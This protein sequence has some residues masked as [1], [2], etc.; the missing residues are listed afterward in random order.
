MLMIPILIHFRQAAVMMVPFLLLLPL[1][2]CAPD[3]L[4]CLSDTLC[5][6]PM[7]EF[8]CNEYLQCSYS[9]MLTVLIHVPQAAVTMVQFLLLLPLINW[10]RDVLMCLCDTYGK[11]Q[12]A[13]IWMQWVLAMYLLTNA[14][15]S[16]SC[17][18]GGNEWQCFRSYWHCL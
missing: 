3:V 1:V 11:Q 7:L 6:Q 2:D 5:K 9:L 8:K 16:L 12:N 18:A 10:G 15:D 14:Y 17:S 4:T 13:W